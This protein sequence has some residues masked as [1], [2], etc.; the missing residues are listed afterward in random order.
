M[1]KRLLSLLL[2]A[3]IVAGAQSSPM[4]R[5]RPSNGQLDAEFI[6]ITGARELSDGRVLVSDP[7]DNRIVVGDFKT[8]AVRQVGRT[9]NGPREYPI[10]FPVTAIAGDSS[11]MMNGLAKR[12]LILVRDSIAGD[13]PGDSRVIAEVLTNNGA[14]RFGNVLSH[15]PPPL[16]QRGEPV[17]PNDSLALVFVSR[18]TG[19]VDTIGRL[20]MGPTRRP[21][22]QRVFPHYDLTRLSIDGWVAVLRHNPFRVDWRSPDGKWTYGKEIRVTLDPVTEADK[23]AFLKNFPAGRVP[24]ASAID[25]PRTIPATFVQGPVMAPDGH[26]LVQRARSVAHPENVYFDIDRQGRLVRQLELAN[27]EQIVAAGQSSVFVS[28]K[29]SDD[30][31]RLRRHPWP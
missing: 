24:P 21:G 15:K 22:T 3:P 16:D 31:V 10:A 20:W 12:W 17:N 23:A 27:G 29:D 19:R 28:F 18:K 1:R 13:V 5:L 7:R 9:G 6:A 8:G 26:L 11:L 30:I 14:D 2:S 4:Q 25:W